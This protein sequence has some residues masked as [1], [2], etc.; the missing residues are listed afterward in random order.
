VRAA[1]IQARGLT[2]AAVEQ[3]ADIIAV[4]QHRRSCLA[5]CTEDLKVC[6]RHR[7]VPL[8]PPAVFAACKG[9]LEGASTPVHAVVKPGCRHESQSPH[10]RHEET[11]SASAAYQGL[12]KSELM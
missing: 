2:F 7:G 5:R 10:P 9:H 11:S 6:H 4:V 8:R 12:P 3:E 1:T